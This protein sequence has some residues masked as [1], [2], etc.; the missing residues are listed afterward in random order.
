VIFLPKNKSTSKVPSKKPT[1]SSPNKKQI[2]AASKKMTP[3]QSKRL[4]T[5]LAKMPPIEKLDPEIYTKLKL[6]IHEVIEK[7]VPEYKQWVDV[8]MVAK[9]CP[10]PVCSSCGNDCPTPVC[11]SCGNDCPTPIKNIDDL[12]TSAVDKA[13]TEAI[14]QALKKQFK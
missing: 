5:I 12:V 7:T 2:D 10:T 3:A 13:M 6:T 14:R 4:Q 11:S 9:D 8:N 1:S